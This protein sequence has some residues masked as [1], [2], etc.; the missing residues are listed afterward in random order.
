VSRSDRLRDHAVYLDHVTL[1]HRAIG[2]ASLTP[3]EQARRVRERAERIVVAIRSGQFSG[4]SDLTR[5]VPVVLASWTV[6]GPN[7]NFF[8]HCLQEFRRC[9]G[10]S[11]A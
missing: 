8:D 6:P 4:V 2:H 9:G 5:P 7:V 10:F 11:Y 1:L 3:P